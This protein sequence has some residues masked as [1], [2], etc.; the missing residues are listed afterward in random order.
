M[1]HPVTGQHQ[2]RRRRFRGGVAALRF[3]LLGAG[4]DLVTEVVAQE[5]PQSTE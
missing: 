2:R 5:P 3:R 4:F 1:A